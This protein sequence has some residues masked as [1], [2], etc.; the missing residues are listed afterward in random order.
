[1]KV[2]SQESFPTLLRTT[3]QGAIISVARVLAA[4]LAA[5]ALIL[6]IGTTPLYVMLT[7][8]NIVGLGTAWLVFRTRDRHDEFRSEGERL[9]TS[10]CADACSQPAELPTTERCPVAW[11]QDAGIPSGRNHGDS[12]CV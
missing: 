9:E 11:A 12:C 5:V 7:I 2:W 6:E 3:A 4:M 10:K 8:F 1:M